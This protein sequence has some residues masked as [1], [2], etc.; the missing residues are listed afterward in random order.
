MNFHESVFKNKGWVKDITLTPMHV[1]SVLRSDMTNKSLQCRIFYQDLVIA[2]NLLRIR[3]S[4]G[5]DTD[6][7]GCK[8][9]QLRPENELTKTFDDMMGKGTRP[10]IFVG[11][12]SP[13]A[14]LNLKEFVEHVVKKFSIQ[15]YVVL[16]LDPENLSHNL[17]VHG[18]N[19][20]SI[21]L[22]LNCK[23]KTLKEVKNA[24]V[25]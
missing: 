14:T 22:E 25:C 8:M 24:T 13:I 18:T 19:E 5:I 1:V 11:H 6:E 12:R 23:T 7:S 15:E 16:L 17:T 21:E 20:R 9:I 10:V 4:T 3:R 2:L